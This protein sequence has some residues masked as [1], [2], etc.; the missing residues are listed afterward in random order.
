DWVGRKAAVALQ[1]ELGDRVAPVQPLDS[2]VKSPT[3]TRLAM[4]TL[5]DEGL[6]TTNVCAGLFVPTAMLPKSKFG[7]EIV[8]GTAGGGGGGGEP[9]VP[10]NVML[11]GLPVALSQTKIVVVALAA[12]LGTYFALML[13]EAPGAR[14]SGRGEQVVVHEKS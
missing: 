2:S 6:F 9:P 7:G 10:L 12:T 11:R 8:S 3:V 1:D 5:A 14:V 4:V 13:Q